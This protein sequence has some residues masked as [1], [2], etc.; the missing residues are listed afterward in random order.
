MGYSPWG[1]KESDTTE[2][3]STGVYLVRYLVSNQRQ[4]SYGFS[5]CQC[6]NPIYI[7][8]WVLMKLLWGFSSWFNKESACNIGDLGS[9]LRWGGSPGK[10]LGCLLQYACLENP[11]DRGAWYVTVYGVAK[12]RTQVSD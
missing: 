11:L 3:L 1:R 6:R 10:G 7:F 4:M 12:G 9:I 5:S 8:W 2:Q